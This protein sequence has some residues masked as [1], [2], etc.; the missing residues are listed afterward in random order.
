MTEEQA[1]EQ[2]EGATAEAI[3]AELNELKT[4]FART[5]MENAPCAPLS[6]GLTASGL[7]VSTAR[8]LGFRNTQE[9]ESGANY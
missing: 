8:R 2:A 7:Q 5:E 9:R 4:T 1:E 3:K 6:L